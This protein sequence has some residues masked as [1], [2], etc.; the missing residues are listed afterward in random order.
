[1]PKV[2]EDLKGKA[3][4]QKIK[5]RVFS[6]GVNYDIGADHTL[7]FSY[8][9]SNNKTTNAGVGGFN[10]P[11]RGFS[12]ENLNNEVK[13]SLVGTFAERFTNQFRS[14]MSFNKSKSI[15]N[16]QGVGITVSKAFNI[17]SSDV[18]N[19]SRV[20]KFEVFE[21]VSS[22]FGKHFIKFGGEVHLESFSSKSSDRTNGNF[23]SIV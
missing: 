3:K 17:G 23:F 20:N 4:F 18:D 11:E 12:V 6:G 21:M 8:Q 2:F 19:S 10:L 9:H 7:R 16:S 15:S 1:M 13:V 5:S 22:G 14:R